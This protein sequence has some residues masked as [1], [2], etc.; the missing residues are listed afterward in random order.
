MTQCP[1]CGSD[2]LSWDPWF[3]TAIPPIGSLK[4]PC[5]VLGCDECSATVT[6][7]DLD[8]VAILLNTIAWRPKPSEAE[9]SEAASA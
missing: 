3:P 9:A 5:F 6:T 1:E 8:A 2:K 7:I 4:H